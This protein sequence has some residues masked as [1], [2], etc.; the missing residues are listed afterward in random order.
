M[1]ASC[2][3]PPTTS[4]LKAA[5]VVIA[6]GIIPFAHIPPELSGLPSDLAPPQRSERPDLERFRGK[7]VLMVGGGSSALE[8]SALLL[9]QGTSI[10]MI[11]RGSSVS[12]PVANPTNPTRLGQLSRPIMHSARGGRAGPM[13]GC[14]TSSGTCRSQPGW[15][16]HRVPRAGGYLVFRDRV[17]GKVPMLSVTK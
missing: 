12:W 2:S 16:E 13:T 4:P 10:K 3:E 1:E 6:T 17:E 5:Q 15:E 7:E 8:T 9:E 11:V 14:P